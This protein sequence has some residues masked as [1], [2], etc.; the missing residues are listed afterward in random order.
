MEVTATYLRRA[1]MMAASHSR[2]TPVRSPKRIVILLGGLV[3]AG[4]VYAA[5][6]RS[7]FEIPDDTV[8]GRNSVHVSNSPS[9]A[10]NPQSQSSTTDR[11]ATLRAEAEK[12]PLDFGARSRYGMALSSAGRSLE[13]L[14]E[15]QKAAR[16]APDVPGVHHNLGVYYLNAGHL[17]TADVEFCR[18]LELAPG[19]G[20]AHYFRGLILQSQHK[21]P[22]AAGQFRAAIALAP[23]L[24]DSYLSLA[25][26]VTRSRDEA[27]VRS[28]ADSYVR[29]GGNKAVA[30]YVVS[31]A[32]RTWK[33]YP[34]AAQ[35]AEMTVQQSPNNYGYWHNLGQIYSYARRWDDADRALRRAQ[36]LAQDPSTV[37]IELGMNAQGAQRFQI[38]EGYFKSALVASPRTGNI[39]H[40]LS[41]LNKL[42]KREQEARNEAKLFHQWEK[43]N[44][45]E[46]RRRSGSPHQVGNQASPQP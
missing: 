23:D 25:I 6:P 41:D 30:D 5:L 14:S 11:L 4:I 33:R 3:I 9:A 36:E 24:P 7:W 13:A 45:A 12:N 22:E 43:E 8:A 28:L 1:H 2:R 26:Q 18:E 31:G 20:R 34:E 35:F 39:H 38:A 19:D 15:F 27:Q 32:Y 44:A 29:L 17:S 40:Y 16:V 42:W 37:L 46:R 10:P 21:D